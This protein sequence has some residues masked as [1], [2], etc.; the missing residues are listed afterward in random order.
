[1]IRRCTSRKGPGQW[2][3][4]WVWF[5]T[6]KS[7]TAIR[8]NLP[9]QVLFSSS[10]QPEKEKRPF[11]LWLNGTT[12]LHPQLAIIWATRKLRSMASRV[13]RMAGDSNP[14]RLMVSN[15]PDSLIISNMFLIFFEH[16]QFLTGK[17]L[18]DWCC[19]PKKSAAPIHPFSSKSRCFWRRNPSSARA[20]WG[21]LW[22][23]HA[24]NCG[25]PRPKGISFEV[26]LIP[27]LDEKNGAFCVWACGK[28]SSQGRL[29]DELHGE[30]MK[31]IDE[32]EEGSTKTTEIMRVA[33]FFRNGQIGRSSFAVPKH[34]WAFL[35]KMFTTSP[36]KSRLFCGRKS[37]TK[38][39]PSWNNTSTNLCESFEKNWTR[40]SKPCSVTWWCQDLCY[41]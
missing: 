31:R 23:K 5:N 2:W 35:A 30:Q 24:L 34:F 11:E 26:I 36:E 12:T 16:L 4:I 25:K 10:K 3:L 17:D 15:L 14:L 13:E 6:I 9:L 1:M 28:P 39:W 21:S 38:R 19:T 37:W 29:M 32:I 33:P 20:T 8:C 18:E 7:D 40:P 27:D 22:L 41:R